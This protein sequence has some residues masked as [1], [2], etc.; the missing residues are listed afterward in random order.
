M[1][2]I[3]YKKNYKL[4]DGKITIRSIMKKDLRGEWWK[5]LNDKKVTHL[6]DKGY[7]KNTIKKQRIYY[8]K[9]KILKK[10]FY[11]LFVKIKN[12]LDVLVYIK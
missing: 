9:L 10:I 7:S 6:M 2:I 3:K 12:I 1:I 4:V 5:W 8:Q 11:L